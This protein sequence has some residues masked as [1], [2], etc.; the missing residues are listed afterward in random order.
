VG[1]R[2][3]LPAWALAAVPVLFL[4]VLFVWPVLTI[5]GRGLSTDGLALLTEPET[6]RVVRFT[7]VQA[8]LS[9]V[10]TLAIALPGAYVTSRYAFRGRRLLVVVMTVP[11]VLPTVVVGLAFRT[12]LP[13]SWVGTLG[14]VLLAHVFFNY[15]VV[16]R[17]VGGLWAQLDPRYEQAARTLGASP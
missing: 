3:P 8:V 6:W 17:I 5:L 11:F 2:G 9:T 7:L 14:A 15:A 12:L 1:T 13:A 16:V 10:L 4:A